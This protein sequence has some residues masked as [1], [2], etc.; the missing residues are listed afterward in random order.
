MIF[1]SVTVVV[2]PVFVTPALAI[3]VMPAAIT[4]TDVEREPGCADAQVHVDGMGLGSAQQREQHEAA[5]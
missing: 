1:V 3:P 2:P 4:V 5:Q